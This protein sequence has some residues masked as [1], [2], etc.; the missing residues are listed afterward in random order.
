MLT[1]FMDKHFKGSEVH[2]CVDTRMR[3]PW[4][5]RE[6]SNESFVQ[7]HTQ[8]A[9]DRVSFEIST[10]GHAKNLK[11]PKGNLLKV[12][13]MRSDFMR[14]RDFTMWKAEELIKDKIK[15]AGLAVEVKYMKIKDA[16]KIMAN[17][18]E[19]FVQARD[20]ARGHFLGDF[21]DLALP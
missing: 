12:N 6:C 14:G 17:D 8:A 7:F 2:A 1:S 19:V 4:N 3:G 18:A 21:M 10:K 16:R 20:D 13:R 9:R 15:A 11:T 5:A